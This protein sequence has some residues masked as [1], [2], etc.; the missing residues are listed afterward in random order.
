MSCYR[1][2]DCPLVPLYTL[3]LVRSHTPTMSIIMSSI[4]VSST[5][6]ALEHLAFLQRI[7]DPFLEAY[8]M[9]A[10]AL[11]QLPDNDEVEGE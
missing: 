2:V 3:S 5:R 6:Q 10:A 7:L 11:L 4:Q 9:A 1:L 8:G